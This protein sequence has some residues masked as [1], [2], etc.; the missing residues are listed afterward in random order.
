MGRTQQANLFAV[1]YRLGM[2]VAWLLCSVPLA[3]AQEVDCTTLNEVIAAATDDFA[4]FRGARRELVADPEM[5]QLN[6]REAFSYSRDEY[7]STRRLAAAANCSVIVARAED[8]G[9][10]ISEARLQCV[11]PS[12]KS[13]VQFATIKKAL[14]A[15]AIAAQVEDEDDDADSYTLLVD[16]VESGEGWGGVSVAADRQSPSPDSGPSVSVIHAVCQAIATGACD[17]D[18]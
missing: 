7:A 14:Q 10:I 13:D 8:P 2:T 4:A 12:A 11:W 18:D 1:R 3:C 9:S 15:C 17:D 16:R 6:D 5:A